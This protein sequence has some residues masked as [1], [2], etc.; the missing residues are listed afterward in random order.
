MATSYVAIAK[1]IF[2]TSAASVTFSSIPATYTDLYML[3]SARATGT[4]G[5]MIGTLRLELNSDNGANYSYIELNGNGSTCQTAVGTTSSFMLRATADGQAAS[6]FCNDE[7]YIPNYAISGVYKQASATSA[8][9]SNSVTAGDTRLS[10][11]ATLWNNTAAI[12]SV[13]LVANSGSIDT[14]S[15]FYLYGIKSS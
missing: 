3:I 2:T 13:K 12:T 8:V 15:S 14:G 6:I 5:A 9:D 4:G 10:A 11:G 1:N 7:L